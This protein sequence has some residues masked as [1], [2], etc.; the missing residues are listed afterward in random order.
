MVNY[1]E[2]KIYQI[3]DKESGAIYIGSTTRKLKVRLDGHKS[4]Y[5]RYLQG[6][7]RFCASYNIIKDD[8]YTIELIE[9]FPCKTKKELL[10]REQYF[11]DTVD[12]INT[13]NS[14]LTKERRA[15][16]LRQNR[17]DKLQY[18]KDKDN[19]RYKII[20]TWGD[21][22]CNFYFINDDLFC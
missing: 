12:C 16:K 7:E 21:S 15:E 13:N 1:S 6:K 5:K 20:K 4:C 19:N 14:I 2:S 18:R 10:T 9:N 17:Q 22:V 8:N 11:I 3:K